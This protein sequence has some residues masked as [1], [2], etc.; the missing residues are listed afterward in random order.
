MRALFQFAGRWHA[1]AKEAGV[2]VE[3]QYD[4]KR[5][6][7]SQRRILSINMI[8]TYSIRPYRRI[9]YLTIFLL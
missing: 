7:H 4:N 2:Y 3:T 5:H 9:Q 8:I 1:R 6:V